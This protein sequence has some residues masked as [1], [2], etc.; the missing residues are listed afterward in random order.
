M[1]RKV[2]VSVS[3]V[4]ERYKIDFT[5]GPNDMYIEV[6][7]TETENSFFAECNYSLWCR[8]QDTPYHHRHP[9]QN[10]QRAVSMVLNSITPESNMNLEDFCWVSEDNR[11]M[12]V[13]GTG[14]L[15]MTN[16]FKK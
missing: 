4:I 1:E 16:N 6:F 15:I 9:D 11:E 14:E 2:N 12:A 3:R 8:K 10:I 7:E 5:Y 13:L